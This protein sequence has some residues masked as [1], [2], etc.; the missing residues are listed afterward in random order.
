M[1]QPSPD[2]TVGIINHN[3][4]RL[5]V[6]CLES[7]F[8][9]NNDLALDVIVVDNATGDGS[10]DEIAACF[11]QVRLI[12]QAEPRGFAANHNALAAL[13]RAPAYLALNDDTVWLPCD[14]AWATKIRSRLVHGEPPWRSD[15][16]TTLAALTR[17]TPGPIARLLYRLHTDESVGAVAPLLVWP[18]GCPQDVSARPFPTLWSD[19]RRYLAPDPRRVRGSPLPAG[20]VAILSGC[21]LLVRRTAWEQLGG[22][23]ER[24]LMFGEDVDFCRRLALAGWRRWFEPQV[25]I[26]HYGSQ[27]TDSEPFR[28]AVEAVRSRTRYYQRHAGRLTAA[29]FYKAATAIL[30]VRWALALQFEP[31]CRTERLAAIRELLGWQ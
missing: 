19:L 7:L 29:L 14:P 1:T 18:D 5:T 17:S 4:H 26:V 20:P 22:L 9:L 2:V 10:A 8:L 30:V 24:F 15:E 11:P 27:S 28:W 25:T 3:P 6:G 21:A 13:A 16:Q 12:R 23:D 31:N